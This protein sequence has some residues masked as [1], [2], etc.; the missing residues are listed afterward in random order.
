MPSGVSAS[1]QGWRWPDSR[2]LPGSPQSL[3]GECGLHA[4]GAAQAAELHRGGPRGRG[5][6]PGRPQLPVCGG[7]GLS[8]EV[9]TGAVARSRLV[10]S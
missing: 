4:R 9:E 2:G 10:C 3:T 7:L 6:A 1:P 8:L 5:A